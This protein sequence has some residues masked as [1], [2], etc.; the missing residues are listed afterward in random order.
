[1]AEL[2]SRQWQRRRRTVDRLHTFGRTF[3]QKVKKKNRLK[4]INKGSN[5][6]NLLK[7]KIHQLRLQARAKVEQIK[8]KSNFLIDQN[9][10]N[11]KIKS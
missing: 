11:L 4:F 8:K 1:M 2:V 3:N 10:S 9:F 6:Q 5:M 7:K